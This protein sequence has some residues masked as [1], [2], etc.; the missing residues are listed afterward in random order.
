MT[1]LINEKRLE[2]DG[3]RSLLPVGQDCEVLLDHRDSG[4]ERLV[5]QTPFLT[6]YVLKYAD[7]PNVDLHI[8]IEETLGEVCCVQLRF[9]HNA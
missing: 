2:E 8:D 7:S 9:A 5:I 3:K 4:D 1:V 6:V